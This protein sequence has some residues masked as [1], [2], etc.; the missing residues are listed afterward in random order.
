MA[1]LADYEWWCKACKLLVKINANR[2]SGMYCGVRYK[3]CTCEPSDRAFAGER[4]AV[5]DR[6]TFPQHLTFVRVLGM[7]GSGF[8]WGTVAM[9]GIDNWWMALIAF[10]IGALWGAKHFLTPPWESWI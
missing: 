4:V 3:M 7:W 5:P 8:G 6:V 2:R 9:L 10:I 1:I